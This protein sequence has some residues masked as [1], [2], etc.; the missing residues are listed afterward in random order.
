MLI[1]I[2]TRLQGTENNA[3]T[4]VLVPL[5]NIEHLEGDSKKVKKHV[6]KLEKQVEVRVRMVFE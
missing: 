6:V 4:C 3:F 5:S 1:L 2:S